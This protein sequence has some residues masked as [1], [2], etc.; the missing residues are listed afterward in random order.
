[1]CGKRA[2]LLALVRK[3]YT[4]R[5]WLAERNDYCSEIVQHIRCFQHLSTCGL[6]GGGAEEPG[7]GYGKVE[8]K[9]LHRFRGC[10]LDRDLRR[11]RA[12]FCQEP[13]SGQNCARARRK[14]LSSW[15]QIGI[16]H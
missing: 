4:V 11:A 5:F 14:S 3:Y 9:D 13:S 12:Q 10:Q 6:L 7:H 16:A 15:Q 2:L 8:P 1:M